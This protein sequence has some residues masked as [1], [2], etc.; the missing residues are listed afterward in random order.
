VIAPV[1]VTCGD[2]LGVGPEVAL[3]AWARLRADDEVAPGE[4]TFVGP[5]ELWARAASLV[6]LSEALRG[7]LVLVPPDEDVEYGHIPEIAAVATAVQGCLQGRYGAVCTGPVHKK[8]L[9]DRGFPFQG[10]TPYLA[11]LCGLSPEEAVMLFAGGRLQV[12]LATVH[13][14]LRAVPETLA[15]RDIVWATRAA[16][17]LLVGGLG[18]PEPRIAVCGLNP[19]AG[20]DG[21]LGDEEQT[22][23]IPAVAVLQRAG[24]DVHG[25]FPADTLFPAA[26]RGRWDLVVA[27]YHDQG[28]IPVKTLDFG[29]S[30][31]ITAGLPIWRTSVDH[32]TARDIAWTGTAD[33]QHMVAALRMA[34]TLAAGPGG[35]G[36]L[37]ARGGTPS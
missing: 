14:P 18:Q 23:V 16:R 34:R 33:P 11:H 30:V 17:D 6:Q 7:D 13:R 25:P 5:L 22:R 15:L 28:L 8:S 35:A 29:T 4:V 19:H 26:A 32:G 20:E 36:A 2:P 24:L 27:L 37:S 3:A 10:H 31:N 12:V 21:A 9:L 1:A